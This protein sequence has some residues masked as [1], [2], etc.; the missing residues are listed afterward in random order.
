[1]SATKPWDLFLETFSALRQAGHPYEQCGLLAW[2]E[3][4]NLFDSQESAE[5]T[6]ATIAAIRGALNVIEQDIKAHRILWLEEGHS[7]FSIKR[8]SVVENSC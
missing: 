5:R 4:V 2:N 3:A 8:K 6:N 1:M 7:R